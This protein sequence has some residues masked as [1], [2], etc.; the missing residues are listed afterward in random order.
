MSKVIA[1]I[2]TSVDGFITG[3]DD[4]PEAGLGVD[5]HRL[6][7]WLGDGD[8]VDPNTY[9]PDG[10]SAVVFDEMM[11]TGAVL[12]GRR[13]FDIAGHWDGDHHDGVPIFILSRHEPPGEFANMPLVTYVDDVTTAMTNR[14][15]VV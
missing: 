1:G 11:E 4:G 8:G 5:G 3:P 13:T 9:R 15:R 14:K 6:H 12:V 2:T 7:A 10:P